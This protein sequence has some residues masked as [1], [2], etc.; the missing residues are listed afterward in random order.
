M[1]GPIRADW[2]MT[3]T[4]EAE[5]REQTFQDFFLDTVEDAYAFCMAG[6]LP[7]SQVPGTIAA[8]Y[9]TYETAYRS[10]SPRRTLLS[11]L[12]HVR[13]ARLEA[14]RTSGSP[15]ARPSGSEAP[16]LE[17]RGALGWLPESQSTVL[18]LCD[19]LG[20]TYQQAA[21]VLRCGE[22]D[23]AALLESARHEVRD[24]SH[25]LA[26]WNGGRPVCNTLSSWMSEASPFDTD[27]VGPL[28]SHAGMCRMCSFV[29]QQ[30]IDPVS[31]L[32]NHRPDSLPRSVRFRIIDEL[33][34]NG[35]MP[36]PTAGAHGAPAGTRGR[37]RSRLS[38]GLGAAGLS[39]LALV[40]LVVAV[41]VAARP[42]TN[43]PAAD[44]R[45]L[46]AARD[47]GA[48][49]D[50]GGGTGQPEVPAGQTVGAT[51]V[52]EQG[53]VT[54][55]QTGSGGNTMASTDS[56]DRPIMPDPV[57]R[58]DQVDISARVSSPRDNPTHTYSVSVVWWSNGESC[59]VTP[60]FGAPVSSFE[61]S[62]TAVFENVPAGSH[63]VSIKCTSEGH[64]AMT[65]EP[66]DLP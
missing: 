51:P 1:F 17:G 8:A 46:A 62:G 29:V 59:D 24:V 38:V 64:V 35:L 50:T 44:S 39:T 11:L 34:R 26:L 30:S 5:V 45:D 14:M 9:A 16:T 10:E 12:A 61:G 57:V 53:V 36:T 48:A 32:A 37:H 6:D 21:V 3:T 56:G 20:H 25:A 42:E 47:D 4:L 28:L 13:N 19:G 27:L 65:T 54:A 60:S 41:L 2:A 43:D 33:C 52:P 49:A 63:S 66:I 40:V 7:P 15:A 55:P 23:V 22:L 58:F 31:E 18:Q